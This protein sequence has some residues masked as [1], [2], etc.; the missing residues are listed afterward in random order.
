MRTGKKRPFHPNLG[1]RDKPEHNVMPIVGQ[2]VLFPSYYWHGTVP[3]VS[4]DNRITIAFDV[5]PGIVSRKD[6]PQS[7]Y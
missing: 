5:V 3:F 1:E 2:L 6:L 4:S 7:A